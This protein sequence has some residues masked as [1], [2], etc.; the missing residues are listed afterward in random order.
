MV[1]NR[2]WILEKPA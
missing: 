1:P 2:P